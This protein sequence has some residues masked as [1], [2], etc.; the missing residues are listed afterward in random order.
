MDTNTFD[1]V[2]WSFFITSSVGLIIA[3]TKMAYKSKCKEV[4]CCCMKIVRDID[5]EEKEFEFSQTHMTTPSPSFQPTFTKNESQDLDLP[6]S[7]TSSFIGC[8]QDYP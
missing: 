3:L 1:A 6:E 4:S 5:T 8:R 2:F 7:K